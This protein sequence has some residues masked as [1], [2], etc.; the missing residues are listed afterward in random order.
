MSNIDDFNNIKDINIPEDENLNNNLDDKKLKFNF[1]KFLPE[2]ISIILIIGLLLT[3]Q[4]YKY[5]SMIS[6]FKAQFDIANYE[7]ANNYLLTTSNFNIFKSIFLEND[8][9]DY[10]QNKVSKLQDSL[11]SNDIS[12]DDAMNIFNEILRYN[13]INPDDTE[14][15]LSTNID[16]NSLLGK[17][18][19]EFDNGNFEEALSILNKIDS[20]DPSYKTASTYITKCKDSIKKDLLKQVDEYKEKEYFTAA[21]NLIQSKLE[22]LSNDQELLKKIEE[23]QAAKS[24]Y[25]SEEKQ[26]TAVSSNQIVNVI[27]TSNINSLNLE[28]L[29][30]YLI[31]VDTDSQITNVYKGSMNNWN[32]VKS[33]RCSTGKEGSETPTG[34]F[35]VREKDEW[36]FSEQYQQGGKYWVQFQGNY[37]FHSVPYA[38]D[39]ETVLDNTLGKA[40]SHGCIRLALEDSK[41][42]YETVDSGTKVIIK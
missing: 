40:V 22:L 14:A 18:I 2:I 7:V 1:K 34:V 42:L 3:Y 17:G 32:L 26:S 19:K 23:L 41:W 12:S 37:L 9:K 21:I 13:I 39:K 29:T 31:Y 6:N 11:A 10:F 4:G 8:L 35:D 36:F 38:K 28:S 25:L 16:E 5:N 33:M 15:V 24:K 27:N 20:S 30:D